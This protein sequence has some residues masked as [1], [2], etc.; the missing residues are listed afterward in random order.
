MTRYSTVKTRKELNSV[1]YAQYLQ[2]VTNRKY[3]LADCCETGVGMLPITIESD[4][5]Q[6]HSREIFSANTR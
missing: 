5:R 4:P 3:E 1:D 6:R 2:N